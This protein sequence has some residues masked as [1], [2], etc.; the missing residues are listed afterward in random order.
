MLHLK[1][2]KQFEAGHIGKSE[3]EHATIEGAIQE[4]RVC[5]PTGPRGGY[6]DIVR[7]QQL[8]NALP[9]NVIILDHKKSFGSGGDKCFHSI[10]GTLQ[11]PCSRRLD[12]IGKRAMGETMFWLI[13][14]RNDLDW[15]VASFWRQ[16]QVVKHGPPEHIRKEDIQGDQAGPVLARQRDGLVPTHGHQPL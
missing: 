2:V 10:E 3:I 1:L 13:L 5:F 11:V 4:Q 15:N 7:L 16:F 9:L 8:D 12:Q 6:F 14:H